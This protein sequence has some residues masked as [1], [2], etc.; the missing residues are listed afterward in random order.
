[1]SVVATLL[2][3]RRLHV[4]ICIY[5]CSFLKVRQQ[6]LSKVKTNAEL[7]RQAREEAGS[8]LTMNR[9]PAMVPWV[10]L[11]LESITGDLLT[12]VAL[13]SDATV[14]DLKRLFVVDA[15]VRFFKRY[16]GLDVD[17]DDIW[18]YSHILTPENMITSE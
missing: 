15:V 9:Q 3:H 17:L 7:F 18:S 16:G 2:E 5:F 6:K 13:P 4:F 12:T 14:Y 10:F 1:M 11:R 8:V